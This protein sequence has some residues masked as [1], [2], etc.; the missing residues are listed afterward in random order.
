MTKKIYIPTEEELKELKFIYAWSGCYIYH[1]HDDVYITFDRF[2]R[3]DL[4]VQWEDENG[5][6]NVL[7]ELSFYPRSKQWL[8]E[9]ISNFSPNA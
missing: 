8:I 5:E 7:S 2:L 1:I 4:F 9:F 6:E 3:F